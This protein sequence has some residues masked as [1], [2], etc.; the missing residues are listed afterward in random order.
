M[1]EFKI[2]WRKTSASASMSSN[3]DEEDNNVSVTSKCSAASILVSA[4][5][6]ESILQPN[7]D[8]AIMKEIKTT[9][10]FI[11]HLLMKL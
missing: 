4:V 3:S 5:F 1:G 10:R 6:A 11:K 7:K 8:N 9:I 2:D